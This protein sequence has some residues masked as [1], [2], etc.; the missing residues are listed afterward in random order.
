MNRKRLSSSKRVNIKLARRGVAA[1]SGSHL[2]HGRGDSRETRRISLIAAAV[3]DGPDL[4]PWQRV[5]R[6]V[7]MEGEVV[8]HEHGKV[9]GDSGASLVLALEHECSSHRGKRGFGL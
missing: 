9:E 2:R 8:P 4:S 3:R 6:H 7:R 1:A 5:P